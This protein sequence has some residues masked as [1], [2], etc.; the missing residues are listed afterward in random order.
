MPWSITRFHFITF[1]TSSNDIALS[2]K[3]PNTGIR[4][5]PTKILYIF[6]VAIN[7]QHQFFRLRSKIL[8]IFQVAINIVLHEW[9]FESC[10]KMI[11]IK[12]KNICFSTKVTPVETIELES[13]RD[14]SLR[15]ED[16]ATKSTGSDEEDTVGALRKPHS[17]SFIRNR[18]AGA[19]SPSIMKQVSTTHGPQGRLHDS[20]SG[21]WSD[22]GSDIEIIVSDS[23]G[24]ESTSSTGLQVLKRGRRR[25]S[26]LPG[27]L[28]PVGK[29]LTVAAMVN[30]TNISA[31]KQNLNKMG[32]GIAAAKCAN[33]MAKIIMLLA[34]L[35]FLTSY[36][37]AV[38]QFI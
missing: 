23:H 5:L 10:F 31:A 25:S 13:P 35:G 16:A 28:F 36:F 1:P 26:I 12:L 9:H 27:K 19:R 14:K 38:I 20:H 8:Y 7:K 2:F 3:S 15:S 11:F 6:N 17:G 24:T 4:Q 18:P 33:L 21:T 32:P 22:G 30:P 37:L 29:L 34:I